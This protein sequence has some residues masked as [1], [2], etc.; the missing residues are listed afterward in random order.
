MISD[1]RLAVR[2]AELALHTK[3]LLLPPRACEQESVEKSTLVD[4]PA[5]AI[6]YP[7]AHRQS[8]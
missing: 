4:E 1:L 5:P 6:T 8:S 2:K 3:L 7:V